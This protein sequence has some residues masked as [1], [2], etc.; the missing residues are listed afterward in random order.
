MDTSTASLLTGK[1]PIRP[2]LTPTEVWLSTGVQAIPAVIA[3]CSAQ[4]EDLQL[5]SLK[6]E[7]M[8]DDKI[9]FTLAGWACDH[10]SDHLFEVTVTGVVCLVDDTVVRQPD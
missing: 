9:C 5:E 1:R 4:P 7:W 10:E 3:F 8:V 6:V 2:D